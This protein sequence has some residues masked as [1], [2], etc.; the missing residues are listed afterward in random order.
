MLCYGNTIVKIN[1][2]QQSIRENINSIIEDNDIELVM[3]VPINV[4]ERDPNIAT[5][6]HHNI[7]KEPNS[8]NCPLKISLV[9]VSQ[10]EPQEAKNDENAIIK[11][12]V[13]DYSKESMLF[14]ID[15]MKIIQSEL[16]IYIRDINYVNTYLTTKKQVAESEYKKISEGTSLLKLVD[17]DKVELN[18]SDTLASRI[19]DLDLANIS[20]KNGSQEGQN[21]SEDYEEL[22]KSDDEEKTEESMPKNKYKKASSCS[23]TKR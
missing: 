21:V 4:D 13:K 2:V 1:Q 3:F 16:Y 12:L 8:N 17:S 22:D 9:S 23:S 20:H 5:L 11:T 19:E 10:N 7:N 18:Q 14:I 6:T 15:E